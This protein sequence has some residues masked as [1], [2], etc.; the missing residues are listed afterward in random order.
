MPD[1][2][3]VQSLLDQIA[4]V[5]RQ[6]DDS[7]KMA[8]ERKDASAASRSKTYDALAMALQL[9]QMAQDSPDTRTQLEGLYRDRGIKEPRKDANPLTRLAKLCFPNRTAVDYSRYAWALTSAELQDQS[10]ERFRSELDQCGLVYV[11]QIAKEIV[12]GESHARA[13]ER[14]LEEGLAV[15]RHRNSLASIEWP[16]SE[17]VVELVGVR[18]EDGQLHVYYHEAIGSEDDAKRR[19]RKLARRRA[20]AKQLTSINK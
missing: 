3:P 16:S 4:D 1:D 19:I 2:T 5:V 6:A 18:G 11:A 17:E 13:M 10:P 12:E 9:H 8:K 14:S 7:A 15:L 20:T